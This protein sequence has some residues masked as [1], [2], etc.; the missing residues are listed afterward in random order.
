[1]FLKYIRHKNATQYNFTKLNS[2]YARFHPLS[3]QRWELPQLLKTQVS[4]NCLW[5]LNKCNYKLDNCLYFIKYIIIFYSY[6]YLTFINN[7]F[8]IH[9]QILACLAEHY[10]WSS[11]H[12]YWAFQEFSHFHCCVKIILSCLNFYNCGKNNCIWY[13]RYGS[14]KEK[15]SSNVTQ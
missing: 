13:P 8:N 4:L 2:T 15:H 11:H 1:M 3:F 12:C 10:I 7:L 6:I 14:I 9:K 5:M